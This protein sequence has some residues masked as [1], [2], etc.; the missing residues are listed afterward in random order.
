MLKIVGKSYLNKIYSYF[1]HGPLVKILIV[2][3]CAISLLSK[4]GQ[5]LGLKCNKS[6]HY[7]NKEKSF[8]Q[9]SQI[10]LM[11]QSLGSGDDAFP[12]V[13]NKDT[14]WGN[15]QFSRGVHTW[16][17]QDS[18]YG[19]SPWLRP[20]S[21]FNLV[22]IIGGERATSTGETIASGLVDSLKA[23]LS[24]KTDAHFLFSFAGQ[25]SKRLRDLD[26]FHDEAT[27]HR[28]GRRTPG[29]Y[30]KT[31]ID[32]VR[33]AYVLAQA[34]HCT[35]GVVAMTWMQ[36]EKNNDRRLDDWTPPLDRNSFLKAYA[37][38]L[39]AYKNNLNSDIMAID[40]QKNR[41]PMF[42][43]QTWGAISGQAQLM[44][45]DKDHEIFIVSPTYYMYSAIN[46]IKW[47]LKTI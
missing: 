47:L 11:G 44:A 18:D 10:I 37:D 28:S 34:C 15:F 38:E 43:Y 26:K 4:Q 20:K 5:E 21:D 40:G 36:G 17:E 3:L 33:R 30:Y 25:G 16:R 9:L 24:T 42:S 35:Y 19:Q 1:N 32:D 22:P 27:D 8:P 23:Q 29:G 31:T 46:S 41:I 12:V 7:N 45:S 39:I 14:H 6:T 13:T 2:V